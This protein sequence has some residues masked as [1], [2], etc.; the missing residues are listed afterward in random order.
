M[1]RKRIINREKETRWSMNCRF[2]T[3]FSPYKQKNIGE[4]FQPMNL[5]P[6]TIDGLRYT[7]I[8]ENENS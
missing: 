3:L 4:F 8:L 6:A 2:K 7:E 1:K 5:K